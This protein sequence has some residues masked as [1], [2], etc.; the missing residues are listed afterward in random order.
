[1]IST[2]NLQQRRSIADQLDD[3]VLESYGHVDLVFAETGISSSAALAAAAWCHAFGRRTPSSALVDL[4]EMAVGCFRVRCGR[5]DYEYDLQTPNA[6]AYAN[7]FDRLD[8]ADVVVL[9][10]V[11]NASQT[12]MPA[13][14]KFLARCAWR[15]PLT[16]API[17]LSAPF[18]RHPSLCHL[19]IVSDELISTD[20]IS[21]QRAA[22]IAATFMRQTQSGQEGSN[23]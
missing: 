22:L 6:A 11:N 5:Q 17:T 12:A 14:L 16:V 19:Q 18:I 23:S 21:D 10:G 15:R 20:A 2:D 8:N 4:S 9:D 1:M 3:L 13:L 7:L